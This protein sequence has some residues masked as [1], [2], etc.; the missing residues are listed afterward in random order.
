MDLNVCPACGAW[1]DDFLVADEEAVLA[2]RACGHRWPFVRLPLFALTGASGAGKSAVGAMLVG[3]LRQV[4]VLEQDL[5]WLPDQLDSGDEH[6]QFRRLWLRLVAA[7]HQN[8]RP[9]LLCGTVVPGQLEACPERRLVGELHY[10]ALVCDDAELEARL[11]ARPAWRGWSDEKVA[12]MLAFNRWVERNAA[13]T[14]PPMELLDTS[15]RSVQDSA[16]D[17]RAWILRRLPPSR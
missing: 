8:G 9:V 2:C 13:A 12:R 17:V 14:T 4:V 1:S 15:G 10:L 5:L 3:R 11:R 7:L 16:A 6:R